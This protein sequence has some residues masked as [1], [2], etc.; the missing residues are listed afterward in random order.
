MVINEVLFIIGG[1]TDE[2]ESV[3]QDKKCGAGFIAEKLVCHVGKS[4]GGKAETKKSEEKPKMGTGKKIAI[5][6]GIAA[7]TL[8]VG[9][10]VGL[11]AIKKS[12]VEEAERL[13]REMYPEV[14]EGEIKFK[15]AKRLLTAS[16]QV[17]A[18]YL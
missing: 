5:G 6:G 11:M 4:G 18:D 3:K 13:E 12:V 9:G 14:E 16:E 15:K 8:L 17:M 7:T 10:F 1:P 2:G